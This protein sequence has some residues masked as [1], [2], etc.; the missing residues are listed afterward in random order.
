MVLLG[1][2]SNHLES[3][4]SIKKRKSNDFL[5][6]CFLH[7]YIY[8]QEVK[9]IIL[10]LK[11]SLLSVMLLMT[12]M[13][14]ANV[15]ANNFKMT[16]VQNPAFEESH[17]PFISSV[18][19]AQSATNMN[20][21]LQYEF[22]EKIF[23]E[24]DFS[25]KSLS[26]FRMTDD[27]RSNY[28][29]YSVEMNEETNYV[30]V[31]ISA[32]FCG[33]YCEGFNKTFVFDIYSG[34]LVTLIDLFAAEG[35][36]GLQKKIIA[37]NKKRIEPYLKNPPAE[38]DP[39]YFDGEYFLYKTCYEDLDKYYNLDEGTSFNIT[40]GT[41]SIIQGRCSNHASR[42]MDEVG[43]FV[44]KFTFK[45]LEPYLSGEGKKYL[46]DHQYQLSSIKTSSKVFHGKVA[47]K[48]P[49]TIIS[50]KG[51][52]WAYWYDKYRTPIELRKSVDKTT[53]E[54]LIKEVYFDDVA[55][56]WLANAHWRVKK[57]KNDYSGTFT[58]AS[59]GKQMSISFK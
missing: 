34:Q 13:V 45:E 5:F 4:F 27:Y 20:T 57:A 46:S 39:E 22:F 32:E 25:N 9:L 1:E 48:Y 47:N 10:S 37:N 38:N 28:S 59:D 36:K 12:S 41:I 3:Y 8:K 19:Y 50:R 21:F 52:Y 14:Y 53:G 23:K 54:L 11:N 17:F 49:I 44:N 7:C 16:D 15:Y 40:D 31:G 35:M 43:R 29:I 58:R 33:A 51:G 30:E 18:K 26:P 24:K 56:K 42:A 6:Y 55:D 2:K